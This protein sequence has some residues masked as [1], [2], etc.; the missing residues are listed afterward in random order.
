MAVLMNNTASTPTE[1]GGSEAEPDVQDPCKDLIELRIKKV[2]KGDDEKDRPN[3]VIFHVT[4]SYVVNGETFKDETFKRG[5]DFDKRGCTD[6][7]YMGKGSFPERNLLHTM[8]VWT[9]RNITIHTISVK[10]RLTVM[11]QP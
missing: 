8:K 4:R 9:G 3:E 11:R 2:W 10:L 5:S 6:L 1:P 7:R